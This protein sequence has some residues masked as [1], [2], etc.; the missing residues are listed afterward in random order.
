MKRAGS[1]RPG[2]VEDG[3]LGDWNRGVIKHDDAVK[4]MG[5]DMKAATGM[6]ELADS[7]GGA[8]FRLT[9]PATTGGSSPS[10][11]PAPDSLPVARSSAAGSR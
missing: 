10:P 9:L 7:E 6:N 4:G 5:A 1:D 11:S 2:F 3:L 8:R